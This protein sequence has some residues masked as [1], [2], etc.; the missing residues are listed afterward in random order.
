MKATSNP[1]QL[2]GMGLGTF[3]FSHV[4]GKITDDDAGAITRFYLEH[5][6]QYIQTAPYYDGVETLLGRAL[7][8]TPRDSYKLATLCVKG[9]DG[10]YTNKRA[11]IIAQVEESLR[12]LQTDYIDLLMP[13]STKATDA[14]PSE[15]I[16]ALEELKRQGEIRAIGVCNV[17]LEQLQEYTNYGQIDYVQNRMS[18]IDQEADR[19]V[20]EYCVSHGIGL[21]PYNVIEWGLLTNKMLT[22][23][24]LHD[25]DLRTKVLPVFSEQPKAI[26]QKWVQQQLKPL[27]D[28]YDTTIESLA[29]AWVL[30]QP[31][32]TTCPVGATTVQQIAAS[33][34]AAQL[35]NNTVLITELQASYASLCETIRQQYGQ[36]L[37][38]FLKNS[39]GK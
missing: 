21:I 36:N 1:L 18:L 33:L 4:F 2:N 39:Y 14:P 12:R 19:D 9:S 22:P 8:G 5:G 38:D 34:Q 10:V 29:I 17:S 37:N 11:H 3:P 24:D 7:Q 27:A 15:A 25:S 13:S 31:G 23:W 32:A 16:A 28:K 30:Q 35:A 26:L 20:R 6:G